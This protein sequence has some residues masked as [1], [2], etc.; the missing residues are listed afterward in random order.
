MYFVYTIGKINL[1]VFVSS[2][3]QTCWVPYENNVIR[4]HAELPDA[5]PEKYFLLVAFLS[6]L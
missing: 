1:A 5:A 2:V 3:A 4:N 6:F